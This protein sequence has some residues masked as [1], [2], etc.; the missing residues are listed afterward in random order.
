ML[1]TMPVDE[2]G[3]DVDARGAKCAVGVV[4]PVPSRYQRGEARDEPGAAVGNE[5][6]EYVGTVREAEDMRDLGCCCCC[7][8]C[9]A[10]SPWGSCGDARGVSM[11]GEVEAAGGGCFGCRGGGALCRCTRSGDGKSPCVT[12]VSDPVL[13]TEED[14]METSPSDDWPCAESANGFELIHTKH[15][16]LGRAGAA[17][18]PPLHTRTAI[19]KGPEDASP[20][21]QV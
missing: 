15:V 10:L 1:L 20:G 13:L 18:V 3:D 2:L 5:D 8:C 6:G 12:A 7:C 21:L 16:A 17:R 11:R 19:S 4:A 9:G 14:E